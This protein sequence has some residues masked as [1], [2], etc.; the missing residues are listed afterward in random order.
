MTSP[1]PTIRLKL[2]A[3]AAAL[4]AC[5]A[6]WSGGTF[7][8]FSKTA[9][10]PG[11]SVSAATVK[12]ADNDTGTAALSLSGATPGASSTGCVV[13]TYSG[14]A[15]AA[16]RLYGQIGGTG[17]ASHLTLTVTRGTISGTPAAG[18]CSGFT[19]DS[20][21]WTGNGP[22]V[23]YTGSLASF[24]TSSGSALPDPSASSTAT[25]TNGDRR[26]YRFSVTLQNDAAAQGKSASAD[27]VWQAVS[28]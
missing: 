15:P 25:W 2:L 11:N 12:L 10:M 27:F 14:T 13:V 16:V 17:L 23:L 7:S 26:A 24:P 9:P 1:A 4:V 18:S 6:V 3:T 19:A 8:A 21:S 28:S 20:T 22:G 5:S